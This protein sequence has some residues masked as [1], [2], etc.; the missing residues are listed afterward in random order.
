MPDLASRAMSET[1]AGYH[2]AAASRIP[3]LGDAGEPHDVAAT[4]GGYSELAGG[5]N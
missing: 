4:V 1:D 3:W 2:P 5:P